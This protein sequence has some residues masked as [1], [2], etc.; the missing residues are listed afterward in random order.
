MSIKEEIIKTNLNID[1]LENDTLIQLFSELQI[2]RNYDKML[3]RINLKILLARKKVY[4]LTGGKNDYY[5]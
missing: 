5:Y 4:L 1:S 3:S 2:T